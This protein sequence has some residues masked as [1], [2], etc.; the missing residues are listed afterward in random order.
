MIS[1][2]IPV[3]KGETEHLKLIKSLPDNYEIIISEEAG[4]ALSLNLGSKKATHEFLWFLHADSVVDKSAIKALELAIKNY[5][6]KLIYFDLKS[7]NPVL[8]LLLYGYLNYF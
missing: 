7:P 5:P 1:V 4:R 8:N 6:R 2:I 3:A